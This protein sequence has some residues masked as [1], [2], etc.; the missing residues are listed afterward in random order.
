MDPTGGSFLFALE[1]AFGEKP[2][3]GFA[4]RG[5]HTKTEMN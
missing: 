5:S 4:P 3:E 2:L 1:K